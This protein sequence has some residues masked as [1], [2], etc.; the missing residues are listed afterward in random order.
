MLTAGDV[1]AADARLMEATLLQLDESALTGESV[2]AAKRADV[3]VS[4]D[5]PLG[6]RCNMVYASCPVV[7][8]SDL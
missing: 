7:S 4:A 8:G 3:M 5:A 6:E 1:V 2:A